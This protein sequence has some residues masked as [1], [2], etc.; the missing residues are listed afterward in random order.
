MGVLKPETVVF[1]KPGTVVYQVY[2]RDDALRLEAAV[3]VRVTPTAYW[4]EVWRSL[5]SAP[6]V[7]ELIARVPLVIE[8]LAG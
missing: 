8:P 1:L 3:I 6:S 2:D 7:L 4:L 5:I